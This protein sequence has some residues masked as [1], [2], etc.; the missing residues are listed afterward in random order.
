MKIYK[1]HK[2]FAILAL[3][4]PMFAFSAYSAEISA[5]LVSG[6]EVTWS[7]T[8]IWEMDGT[9]AGRLPAAGDNVVITT[10]DDGS[11]AYATV[12][13]VSGNNAW[14][15]AGSLTLNG[16]TYLKF[17]SSNNS[18]WGSVALNSGSKLEVN[19]NNWAN[20][21]LI[22]TG[23]E[24]VSFVV[25]KGASFSLT[26]ANFLP[27]GSHNAATNSIANVDIKGNFSVS[28]GC[29][30]L[31]E[32]TDSVTNFN[33]YGSAFVSSYTKPDSSDSGFT[34]GNGYNCTVNMS[35]KMQDVRL[36]AISGQSDETIA[37]VDTNSI[38]FRG[39][40][41][42]NFI[43]DF[44]DFSI[45]GGNFVEGQTYNFALMSVGSGLDETILEKFSIAN[46]GGLGSEWALAGASMEEFLTISDNTLYLNLS[47]VPEPSTYAAIFGL[48]A[49]LLALRRKFR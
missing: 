12:N 31:A 28:S 34:F 17:S 26:G 37:L 41:D 6:D 19:T 42:A 3:A 13:A 46:E 22:S 25:E 11:G 21:K 29:V 49:L 9:S 23:S 43:I 14:G 1:Q 2:Q 45:E 5:N 10:T 24:T 32:G 7:T 47:R 36:S 20:F 30:L 40:V 15:V 48:A 35:F 18:A 8:S 38:G 44:A 16:P 33:V 39:S 27:N 4:L